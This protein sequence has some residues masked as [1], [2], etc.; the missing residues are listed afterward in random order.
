[1]IEMELRSMMRGY[2]QDATQSD[3]PNI[4]LLNRMMEDVE[5]Y[6]NQRVI[7]DRIKQPKVKKPF[8]VGDKWRTNNLSTTPGGKTVFVEYTNGFIK[9]YD[10]IKYPSKFIDKIYKS[11]GPNIVKAWMDSDGA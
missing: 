4:M 9:E 10:K 2:I 3:V 7:E 1:M 8:H 6:V 11:G 5:E